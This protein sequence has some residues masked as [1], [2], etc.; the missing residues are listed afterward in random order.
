[1]V[2]AS[3]P[4]SRAERPLRQEYLSKEQRLLHDLQ[5]LADVL[6]GYG[7]E[8]WARHFATQRR[9][10][11][12]AVR[13]GASRSRKAAIAKA[14]RTAYQ[15]TS[16]VNDLVIHPLNGHQIGSGDLMQAN[17][18]LDTLRGSVYALSWVYEERRF[19]RLDRD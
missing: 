12:A 13:G 6:A 14:I 11:E 15:G 1:V 8:H 10:L 3:T 9:V 16:T 18:R 5:S 19:R 7:E 2:E 4:R 17:H